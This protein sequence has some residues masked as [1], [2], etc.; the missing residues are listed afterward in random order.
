M[1]TQQ[2]TST[3]AE[4]L[5]VFLTFH[6]ARPGEQDTFLEAY[7]P[8]VEHHVRDWPGFVDATLFVSTDGTRVINHTRWSSRDAYDDF[9]E[10]SDPAP[11]L[12]AIETA[13][14]SAPGVRGPDME[15]THTYH[16]KQRVTPKTTDELTR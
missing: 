1:T 8:V 9:L 14:A 13:L 3:A 11:R 2:P 6:L 4:S 7:L 5:S 15:V 16:A 10:R 12:R